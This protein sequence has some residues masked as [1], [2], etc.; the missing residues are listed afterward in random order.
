MS[1]EPR[2]PTVADTGVPDVEMLTRSGS[3][4]LRVRCTPLPSRERGRG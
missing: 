1:V 4:E 3:A 2:S